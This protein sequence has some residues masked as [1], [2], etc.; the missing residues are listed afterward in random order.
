MVDRLLS[1]LATANPRVKGL[2]SLYTAFVE[3]FQGAPYQLFPLI[4]L[5]VAF[6]LPLRNTFAPP[7]QPLVFLPHFSLAVSK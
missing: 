5:C 2:I 4:F 3:S 7:F 6:I 1:V